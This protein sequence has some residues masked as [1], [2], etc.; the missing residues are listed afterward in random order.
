MAEVKPWK[1]QSFNTMLTYLKTQKG[2]KNKTGK[3]KR[4]EAPMVVVTT[5][6]NTSSTKKPTATGASF[7]S[8]SKAPSLQ[9]YL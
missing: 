9:I 3:T 5:N 2:F 6:V 1:P 7:L 8:R 4:D